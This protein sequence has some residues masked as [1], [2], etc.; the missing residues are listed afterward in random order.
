VKS[1]LEERGLHRALYAGD[2]TTDL[3]GFA[4]IADLELGVR[5]AIASPEGPASLRDTADLV[6][7]GPPELLDLLR[8]L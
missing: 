4:A 1:L 7:A 2:D 3:D 5:V 6:V 8:G